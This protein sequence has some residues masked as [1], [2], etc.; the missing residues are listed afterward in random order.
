MLWG[1]PENRH[2]RAARRSSHRFNKQ[3]TGIPEKN[4]MTSVK[5]TFWSKSSAIATSSNLIRILTCACLS[6]G[7]VACA[8]TA[9]ETTAKSSKTEA[10]ESQLDGVTGLYSQRDYTAAIAKFDDVIADD[11]ASANDRRLAASGKALIYLGYDRE[12]RDLEK[13]RAAL[14]VATSAE[15]GPG[16]TFDAGTNL[17]MEAVLA[18][19][20]AQTAFEKMQTRTAGEGNQLASLKKEN[21]SL[22]AERDALKKENA[23]LNEAL[24]RLKNL[25]LGD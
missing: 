16:E 13:A 1:K 18:L 19:E 9:P 5:T 14:G 11:Q 23:N 4:I 24:E 21:A 8:T 17:F 10:R 20:D 7:L 15:A 2:A 12:W 22:E 25:T 6:I 3:S